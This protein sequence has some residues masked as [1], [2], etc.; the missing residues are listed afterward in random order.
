MHDIA[1]FVEAGGAGAAT[2]ASTA[3]DKAMLLGPPKPAAR[4]VWKRD[5]YQDLGE[6]VGKLVAL[7]LSSKGLRFDIAPVLPVQE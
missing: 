1:V 7:R 4:P 3:P 6:P 2:R 5:V